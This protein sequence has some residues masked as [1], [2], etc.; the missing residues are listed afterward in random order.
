MWWKVGKIV[1]L[2]NRNLYK[3]VRMRFLGNIE[4][5]TDAK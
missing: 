2:C 3:E 5:K 1:Y 4:A